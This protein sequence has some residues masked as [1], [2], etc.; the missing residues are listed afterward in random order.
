M[1]LNEIGPW[2]MENPAFVSRLE[3]LTAS[4]V[5]DDLG[6][7]FKKNSAF[8]DI[9]PD[10]GYLLLCGSFLAS[11]AAGLCQAAALRIAHSCLTDSGSSMER[12]DSAAVLLDTLAN[13]PALELAMSRE[14]LEPT[15][16][17]RLPLPVRIE[18][19]RRSIDDSISVGDHSLRVN[20]FQKR[21]WK[22][23]A[24]YDWLSVSAPTSAGKS[25]IV[26]Q[27]ITTFLAERSTGIIIYIVPTRA[28]IS[29]VERDMR[30]ALSRDGVFNS[31]VIST[32]VRSYIKEDNRTVLVFT[33]ERLHI[34]MAADPSL[35]VAAL[36][37][38]EAHKIGDRTRGVL[39]Q[40]VI[41]SVI[42]TNP[43][44]KVIFASPM[45]SNPET[46]IADVGASRTV[47]SLTSD[48]VMVSQNLIWVS[49]M[50]RDP[51]NWRAQLCL[52]TQIIELG[53]FKLPA[54]PLPA[55]KRLPFVAA[56]IGAKSLR[57]CGLRQRCG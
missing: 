50:P 52:P 16:S 38:D 5:A 39:L 51:M 3:G 2:L 12:K 4:A 31:D 29:Q 8:V 19:T 47:G 1:A 28:L 25:F 46:L 45:S 41:E 44:V 15:L 30:A 54:S 13:H 48:D 23:A 55:S 27:W 11:S 40:Q 33:Q 24:A 43:S 57:K 32:P 9:E 56:A 53:H 34:L 22:A 17:D 21:F 18:W 14:L 20:R 37:V 26:S 35:K 10:W 36:V 42:S 7:S 6:P 49:Q